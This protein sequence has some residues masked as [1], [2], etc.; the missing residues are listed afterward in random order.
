MSEELSV[1]FSEMTEIELIEFKRLIEQRYEVL[2]GDRAKELA[3]LGADFDPYTFSGSRK[4]KNIVK[5]YQDADDGFRFLLEELLREM[6]QRNISLLDLE[7][8]NDKEEIDKLSDQEYIMRELEKNRKY[9][10]TK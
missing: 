2:C 10:K 7:I 3:A 5:K 6:K 1:N 9:R 8:G 4:I